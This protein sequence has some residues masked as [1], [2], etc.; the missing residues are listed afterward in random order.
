MAIQNNNERQEV[1]EREGGRILDPFPAAYDELR[2]R[3]KDFELEQ[4]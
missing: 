4:I 3:E 2:L 1:P